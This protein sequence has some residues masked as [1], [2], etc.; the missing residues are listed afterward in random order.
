[1]WSGYKLTMLCRQIPRESTN[2]VA[3][4]PLLTTIYITLAQWHTNCRTLL[5]IYVLAF[6]G[7]YS[8]FTSTNIE[9]VKVK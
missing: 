7:K 1:M 3:P 2:N 5:Y 4:F 6:V 8:Q 9:I